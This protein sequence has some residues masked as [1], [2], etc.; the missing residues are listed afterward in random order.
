MRR[1]K[2]KGFVKANMGWRTGIEE[3]DKDLNGG[4]RRKEKEEVIR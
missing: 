2:G 4:G 3:T 1:G